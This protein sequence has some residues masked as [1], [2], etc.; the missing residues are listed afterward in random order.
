MSLAITGRVAVGDLRLDVDLSV[1][2]GE[3]LAVLGPNGAGKTTLL[4]SI[5]GLCPLDDGSV[6]LD[7]RALD[8][9]ADGVF[10]PAEDR[11]LGVVFQGLLLF[12]HL[13]VLENVAF[14]LRARGARRA[15]ARATAARWLDRVGLPDRGGSAVADLS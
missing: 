13:D 15:D 10:V 6:T 7:G 8:A 3:T 4:R 14:G 11:S 1:E 9:P 12:P 2:P 5:A